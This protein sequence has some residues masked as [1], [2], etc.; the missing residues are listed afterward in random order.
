MNNT[1]PIAAIPNFKSETAEVNGVRLHYW[2]GG[3]SA[4]QPILLWHGFLGTAYSWH[5]VMPLLAAAGY[6]VLVP[7]MR[8]YGDSDKPDGNEG[9]D[10]RALAEEFRALARQIDFGS[11]QPLIIAELADMWSEG[12]GPTIQKILQEEI[13]SKTLNAQSSATG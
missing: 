5:K 3:A 13:L 4:G 6:A 11:G 12:D 9:Y 8:G 10:A 7:D 2:V 1:T